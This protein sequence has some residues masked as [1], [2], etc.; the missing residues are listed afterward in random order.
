[1][2]VSLLCFASRNSSRALVKTRT[3]STKIRQTFVLVSIL[4]VSHHTRKAVYGENHNNGSEN[5]GKV[6]HVRQEM[7]KCRVT[8]GRLKFQGN[9][10]YHE[11]VFIEH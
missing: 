6:Q 2:A 10:L 1:M 4:D 9:K 8:N 3:I 5:G 11:K 7:P